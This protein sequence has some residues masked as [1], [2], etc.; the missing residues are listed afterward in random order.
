LIFFFVK[1]CEVVLQFIF[2][3]I[4]FLFVK[5]DVIWSFLLNFLKQIMIFFIKFDTRNM[6]ITPSKQIIPINGFNFD[7][8]SLIHFKKI[9]GKDQIESIFHKS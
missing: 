5:I 9:N 1:K 8:K 6:L 4:W 7:E 2:V 3:S